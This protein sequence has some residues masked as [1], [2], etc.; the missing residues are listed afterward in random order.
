MRHRKLLIALSIFNASVNTLYLVRFFG[1]LPPEPVVYGYVPWFMSFTL[2]NIFLTLLAWFLVYSLLKKSDT[3]AATIGLINAGGLIF[4]ALN[5]LMFGFYTGYL[6]T[7]T[8]NAIFEIAVYA[9]G[10]SLAAFYI[11]QF[12]KNIKKEMPLCTKQSASENP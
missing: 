11:T 6:S 8:F 9:Y 3:S 2:P 5:G 1:V 4:H 10:L 12:S 7:L